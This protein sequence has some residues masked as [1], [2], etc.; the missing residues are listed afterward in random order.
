MSGR[1]PTMRF[2]PS[3]KPAPLPRSTPSDSQTIS[4]SGVA[5]MKRSI[6][7][8]ASTRSTACGFGLSCLICTRAAPATL[9]RNIA[10]GF[11]QRQHGDAAIVGFGA[12]DQFI[13]GA[14]ARIPGRGRRP[15]VVEQDQQRRGLAGGRERRIPLRAGGG[16][17]DERGQ[18]QPQQGQPPRRARRGFFLGRDFEQQP[19]RRE[20]D[21]GA[22]AAAPAA[23][24]TTAAAGS[25]GRAAPA[26]ARSRAGERPLCGAPAL[27]RRMP[28]IDRGRDRIGAHARMQREQQ[29]GRAA[30][31]A[32]NGE[33]PAELLGLGAQARRDDW[34]AAPG[35]RCARFRRGRR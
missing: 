13:G 24:A 22:G 27:R 14:Q 19:R 31:G 29:F 20:I 10:R 28:A 5:L 15:A 7:G 21:A 23:A 18:R 25:A 6:S 12:R 35:N 8:S 34:P 11:R 9:Q 26:V 1:V 4:T 30:I 17:N 2:R 33:G 16:D 3:T 32:M